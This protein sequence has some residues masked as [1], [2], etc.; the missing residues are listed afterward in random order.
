[1]QQRVVERVDAVQVVEAPAAQRRDQSRYV[2]RIRHQHVLAA[3]LQPGEHVRRQR[4]DVIERQRGENHGLLAGLQQRLVQHRRRLQ[5]IGHH[6]AMGQYRGLGYA[7]RAAGVLQERDVGPG[8]L[9]RREIRPA[10]QLEHLVETHRLRQRVGRDLLAHVAQHEIDERRLREAEPV[11]DAGDD[12]MP[13]RR[14]VEHFRDNVRCLLEHDDRARA[15]ILELVDELAM[16]VE[17]V[18]VDDRKPGAQCAEYA[19]RVLQQVRH[20]Q[21]DALARLRARLVLQPSREDAA[22]PVKRG[23]AQRASHAGVGGPGGVAHERL[24]DHVDERPVPV[25][26]DL[27][28]HARRIGLEPRTL[29]ELGPPYCALRHRAAR[30]HAAG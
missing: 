13:Q 17:R 3:D 23:E 30:G 24:V 10:T 16:R 15:G 14:L 12:D 19:D 1:M 26:V 11:A 8:D 6:V 7:G 21:R 4:E 22:L 18:R 5:R 27:R 29:H 28:R 2:A 9:H 25:G 20:H